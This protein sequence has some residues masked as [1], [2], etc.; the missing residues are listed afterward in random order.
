[1]LGDYSIKI[2][3]NRPKIQY[4]LLNNS[5]T[6]AKIIGIILII[7]G[8]VF[9]L[10]PTDLNIKIGFI[11]ICLGLF[12][13]FLITEKSIPKKIS[14]ALT[15][16]NL[17]TVNNLI[18]ELNLQGNAVFLPKSD[19]LTE[20]R[21]FIPPNKSGVLKI[22]E[23][24]NDNI[25][26][27]AK[28]GNT[29]GLSVPPLGIALLNEIQKDKAFKNITIENIEEKLQLFAGM[30]LIRSISL[31]KQKNGWDLEIE[32]LIDNNNKNEIY[33]QYPCPISSAA[34]TMITRVLNER[35]RIYSTTN[36]GKKIMFHLNQIKKIGYTGDN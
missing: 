9:L 6:R 18:K 14:D 2:K 3:T 11:L 17:D 7:I 12:M 22:P 16:V 21:I 29:L 24:N 20:E 8:A 26:L 5:P 32:N 33:N 27:I 10:N 19:S 34:I 30:N 15:E 23:I 1:M 28:D 4:N 31:K 25:I 35:I 36:N 13:I